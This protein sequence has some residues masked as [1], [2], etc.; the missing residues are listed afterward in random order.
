MG[1]MIDTLA[2][3][4]PQLPRAFYEEE[5]SKRR[6]IVMLKT[7]K[8]EE[9]PA[10][11]VLASQ[12]R[13]P[14]RRD[15]PGVGLTLLYSHGNAEDVALH[16]DLLDALVEHTGADV[17]SY[18][19]VGYSTSKLN[20]DH[21]SEA[22]CYRSADAAWV[23]CVETL[24]I[25]PEKIVIY[26]RSIGSAPAIDLAHRPTVEGTRVSPHSVRG[27]ILQSPVESGAR[28]IF[29]SVISYIGYFVDPFKNYEKIRDVKVPVAIMHGTADE[30]VPFS[31][32]QNLQEL[33]SN[34]FPPRWMDGYGHNNMPQ[35]DC[36]DYIAEF[37]A[38]LQKTGRG[39]FM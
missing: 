15:S 18:E 1:G 16:L 10:C 33:V 31:N 23:H 9:I 39:G 37:L 8:G 24:K 36:F 11:H 14:P 2:F 17:F 3:P 12:S 34:K 6:D 7:S 22:G 32:G 29:G 13:R 35:E 30:V 21:P 19:Y 38:H 5:F 25:P 28:A 20:G 27:L 26:G 4:A